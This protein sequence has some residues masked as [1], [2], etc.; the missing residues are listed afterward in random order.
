MEEECAPLASQS[1]PAIS[2]DG[3]SDSSHS[4]NAASQQEKDKNAQSN[5]CGGGAS[6]RIV[7]GLKRKRNVRCFR[8]K[9]VLSLRLESTTFNRLSVAAYFGTL[10][11][12]FC[13][14]G[15]ARHS[16]N[17]NYTKLNNC[18]FIVRVLSCQASKQRHY[19]VS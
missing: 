15:T 12:E 9:K 10:W 11:K 2:R 5:M 19:L 4:L 18:I 13:S 8:F 6:R 7:A 17:S 16:C 3:S 1:L 14:I